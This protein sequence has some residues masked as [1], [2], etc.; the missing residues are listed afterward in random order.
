MKLYKEEQK[1][2]SFEQALDT[3]RSKDCC[4]SYDMK[5]YGIII[6]HAV[7]NPY[8]APKHYRP[9]LAIHF[10]FY[11]M[12]SSFAFV[13]IEGQIALLEDRTQLFFKCTTSAFHLDYMNKDTT[14]CQLF[15]TF[16]EI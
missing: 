12:S 2:K 13:V 16:C 8:K 4:I 1:G 9:E 5:V 14:R 11:D 6:T 7:G 10:V 15:Q 3:S